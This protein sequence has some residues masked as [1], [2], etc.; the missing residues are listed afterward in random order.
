[1]P[2]ID[3]WCNRVYNLRPIL[4]VSSTPWPAEVP[5]PSHKLGKVPPF[6][7]WSNVLWH[8][9][10]A[11]GLLDQRKV[12]AI[13]LATPPRNPSEVK[14]LRV[15]LISQLHCVLLRKKMS[16]GNG[17]KQSKQL[18]TNSSKLSLATKSCNISIPI[19]PR[20]WSSTPALLVLVHC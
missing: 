12:E 17:K 5:Q 3:E 7:I 8:I 18:L 11:E 9:F 4:W 1:M 10:S 19:K 14:S 20:K 16:P 15:T 6:E 2:T 13:Q